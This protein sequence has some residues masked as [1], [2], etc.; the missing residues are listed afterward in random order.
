MREYYIQNKERCKAYGRNYYYQHLEQV[1]KY[2]LKH[3]EK[4]MAYSKKYALEN[5]ERMKEYK[6]KNKERFKEWHR[7]YYQRNKIR[8]K[9]KYCQKKLGVGAETFVNK[10]EIPV[11]AV[12]SK[13]LMSNHAAATLNGI[14]KN[15]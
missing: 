9:E 11:A 7:A 15:T 14:K 1:K 5:R 12:V 6:L 8:I 3:R 13:P 2:R 10:G 4:M